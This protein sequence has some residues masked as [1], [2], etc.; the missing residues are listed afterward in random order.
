[1]CTSFIKRPEVVDEVVSGF[2]PVIKL[3][4]EI[5]FFAVAVG[6]AVVEVVVTV[7]AGEAIPEVVDE[8]V[9]GFESVLAPA[10]L[11]P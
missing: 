4:S 6:L 7:E 10:S 8:V 11:S 9:F 5:S 2:E 1:M 3:S